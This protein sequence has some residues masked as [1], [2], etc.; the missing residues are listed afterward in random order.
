MPLSGPDLHAVLETVSDEASFIA[1]LKAL[2]RDFERERE[3]EKAQP[4]PPYSAGAL[5]WESGTIGQFLEAANAY[6]EDSRHLPSH[7]NPW[8]RCAEILLAGKYYE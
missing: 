4:R 6:G 2:G 7:P 1:F 3:I 8:R 5:G